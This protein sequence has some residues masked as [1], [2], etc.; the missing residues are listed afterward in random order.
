VLVSGIGIQLCHPWRPRLVLR[1]VAARDHVAFGLRASGSQLLFHFYTN[2]DY[3]IV[4]SCF[5]KPALGLY[6]LAY[7][8]V[9]EPVRTISAVVATIAFPL[10]ARLRHDRDR[11]IAQLVSLTR[12][13]LVT[14][15]TYAAVVGIGAE[16]LLAALFPGKE[17]AA[18]AIQ[19]LCSVAVLRAVG[20]VIPP[21]LDGVGQPGR[22]FRYMLVAAIILPACFVA[23]ALGLGDRLG[24]LSVATAW[25]V[26]YPVAF[27]VLVWLA[28][29]TIG[30]TARCYFGAIAGVA[31][32]SAGAALIGLVVS[33]VVA[34]HATP[35]LRLAA[36]ATAIVGA[37]LALLAFTQRLGP[38]AV[39]RALRRED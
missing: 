7:D 22:T 18:P 15:L 13:N 5:G 28:L 35:L 6:K 32:C 36:T 29:A 30:W 39:L 33:L 27:A 12:L 3:P 10:F 9:L 24:F 38:R 8:V 26:G 2:I 1:L 31:A 37:N 21:L 17:A 25:A 14:V 16:D 4:G 23:G 19:I 11:L 20:F 34:G